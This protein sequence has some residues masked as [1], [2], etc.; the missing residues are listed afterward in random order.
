MAAIS[1]VPQVVAT[2]LA[3]TLAYGN[4]ARAQLGPGG[5]DMTRLAAS[6]WEMWKPLLA[7]TPGRT[8]AMLESIE[9]ELRDA[10]E[11]IARQVLDD[12]AVTWSVARGWA[13]EAHKDA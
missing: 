1:H 3:S 7:A 8:L 12:A 6:S 9:T 5:R 11:A 2:A 4:V 13:L 10:R